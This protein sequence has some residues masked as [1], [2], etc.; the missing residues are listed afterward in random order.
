M[1]KK[2][3][4]YVLALSLLSSFLVGCNTG[5]SDGRARL[6]AIETQR[7]LDKVETSPARDFTMPSK[8]ERTQPPTTPTTQEKVDA[9]EG[10]EPEETSET[11]A[12]E[13]ETAAEG[14]A[15]EDKK[16]ED[17]DEEE[18][19]EEKAKRVIPGEDKVPLAKVSL[20]NPS[21]VLN[22]HTGTFFGLLSSSPLYF[23][24]REW[25]A[26]QKDEEPELLQEMLLL[27]DADQV[28]MKFTAE[29]GEQIIVK[30]ANSAFY[31]LDNDTYTAIKMDVSSDVAKQISSYAFGQLIDSAAK[32]QYTGTGNA[33]FHGVQAIFEEFKTAEN[34][35]ARYY[36]DGN[37]IPLGHRI[38]EDGKVT[39]DIEIIL[40]ANEVDARFFEIPAIYAIQND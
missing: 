19:K 11:V 14:E 13:G 33:E 9:T 39:S 18:E 23:N 5:Q 24:Y 10:E 7:E 32:I 6:D 3:I 27:L 12:E 20:E 29:A 22:F 4:L 21:G 38:I 34:A 30:P 35:Y 37:G 40:L 16:E 15:T 17:E 28:Y 26:P 36:F 31:L 2:A 25:T 1:L 8:T